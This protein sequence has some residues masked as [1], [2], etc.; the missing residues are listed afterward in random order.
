MELAPLLLYILQVYG[1]AL[2]ESD[3]LRGPSGK[4]A[5]FW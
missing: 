4:L 1:T 5:P 2:E 3:S